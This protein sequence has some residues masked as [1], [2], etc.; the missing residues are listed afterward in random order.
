ML[1]A[2][3]AC[4][5]PAQQACYVMAP[6]LAPLRRGFLFGRFIEVARGTSVGGYFVRA[7]RPLDYPRLHPTLLYSLAGK[8]MDGAPYDLAGWPRDL[9]K[10]TRW[11][12]PT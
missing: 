10:S 12:T 3:R 8:P 9:V 7:E 5:D 6:R 4:D 1:A 11:S 2:C